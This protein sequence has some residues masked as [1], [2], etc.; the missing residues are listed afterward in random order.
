F[1][2][3]LKK[4]ILLIAEAVVGVMTAA[5]VILPS[6][7]QVLSNYRVSE[8]MYG[9]DMVVYSDKTRILRII[10]AFFMMSDMPARINVFGADTGRWA[11]LAGY[12]PLFSMCGVVAYMKHHRKSWLTKSVF[13]FAFM[14]FIPILNAAFVLFNAS[15]YARW[16]YMPILLFCLMT[17]SVIDE[18]PRLLKRGFPFAAIGGLFF[19]GIGL[20]PT[21]VEEKVVYAK[22][23]K[24]I[25]LYWIQAAVTV[26]M[27]VLLFVLVY[28]ISKTKRDFCSAACV[29]T[30]AACVVCNSSAVYYGVAQ[31]ADNSDYIKRVINGK[32]D[33]NMAKLEAASKIYVDKNN[34]YRI[35][36]SDSTDNWCMFW[37]LSSMRCFH[38]VVSTSIMDFYTEMGQTRDVASR[39]ERK[40]FPLRALFSVKYYFNELDEQQLESEHPYAPARLNELEGFSYVDTQNGFNIYENENYIPMGFAYDYYTT[41]KA[42]K[43]ASEVD[44]TRMLMK[45]LV[46][47][48]KQ[49]DKYSDVIKEYTFTGHDYSDE[50]FEAD[51]DN[52][53]AMSCSEFEY[54]SYGFK[55]KITLDKP[56]LVFFSVPF[57]K[58]WS[59]K[60][61]GKAAQI[62]KVDYGFMAVLCPAGTSAI[63]FSYKAYGSS[64]GKAATAA[65]ILIIVSYIGADQLLAKRRREGK[66]EENDDEDKKKPEDNKKSEA[67][68]D[69]K[70]NK[71]ENKD[72]SE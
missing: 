26:L 69:T 35:D 41:D 27:L 71:E 19:V 23:A 24:Y 64:Y 1:D 21:V 16:F 42:V 38:S 61:N 51:C 57:D 43:D 40:V 49:A 3:D 62:E 20:L 28:I 37:D 65:G 14:A 56:R 70:D 63:D 4:F 53:R 9:L 67:V 5:V 11:S 8:R 44:K 58:G 45:A 22:V 72:V 50:S 32:D 52:R 17:S 34:F 6:V 36:S 46:L 48:K 55:A 25:D 7:L 66:A 30:A 33:I 10:Q 47:D 13:V 60:V 31:G 39:M 2:V 54:D 29:M 59:A 68:E 18:D 12:L 15:Y